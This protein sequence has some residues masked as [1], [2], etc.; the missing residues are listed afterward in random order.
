[1]GEAEWRARLVSAV[2][3]QVR[4]Y[5]QERGL[6][7]QRL[8]DICTEEYGLPIK[9]S[10]LANFEGGR[11]P[12]LSVV[13]LLALARI[14]KVPPILLLFPLGRE[15]TTE[16]LPDENVGTWTAFKWFVGE[17]RF[18]SE[19]IPRGEV[20]AATGLPEW[21]DDPEEGWEESAAPVTL[22]RRHED[23]VSEWFATRRKL[24]LL[25]S[26]K[27]DFKEFRS[28]PDPEAFDNQLIELTTS[29][30]HRIEVSVQSVRRY[31]TD[32]GIT[33]PPSP[34]EGISLRPGLGQEDRSALE[35]SIP[36]ETLPT[37]N[38]G[39]SGQQE[40]DEARGDR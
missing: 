12:A 9:R 5:R 6:S 34:F 27:G 37:D 11:R 14:L 36:M 33:P 21:Y 18:P 24:Q 1:M 26:S 16:V 29:T 22:Y 4:R 30:L 2:A 32:R 35:A 31:M 3:Q 8:A 28:E 39:P 7:V 20:D 40:K 17:S 25:L 38:D 10:V 23:L 13:E 19:R 15:E